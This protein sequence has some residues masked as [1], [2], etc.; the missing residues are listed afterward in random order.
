MFIVGSYAAYV[1]KCVELE[2]PR[3]FQFGRILITWGACKDFL[4][5]SLLNAFLRT[6]MLIRKLRITKEKVKHQL[7]KLFQDGFY[8]GLIGKN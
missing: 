6:S 8:L 1:I 5:K 4:R 3:I 2:Y 7:L